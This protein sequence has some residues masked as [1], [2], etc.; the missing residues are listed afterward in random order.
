M[1]PSSISGGL[2]S[3]LT[4]SGGGGDGVGDVRVVIVGPQG[5]SELVLAYFA[6]GMYEALSSLMG[7]STDRTVVLDNLELVL[8]LIDE[9]CDGG[10]ILETDGHKLVSSVLLR[11]EDP[12]AAASNAA[13]PTSSG[14]T[15][16][17][18]TGTGELTIGQAL[19][20]AREQLIS[21]LGQ[22]DGM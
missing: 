14:M 18:L 10:V 2:V 4:S 15:G 21:Q 16:Q 1:T 13:M 19:R 17:G 22:R 12:V 11:D 9:L 7:G 20:Q 5:E 8:L 6:E 3:G